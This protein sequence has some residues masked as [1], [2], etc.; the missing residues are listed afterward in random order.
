MAN[1]GY[2]LSCEEHRPNDLIR[3]AK[4]AEEAGFEF[5]LIS[6]HFHPWT[7]K[8]GQSPFAWSVLGGIAQ[9]TDKL[10]LGTGVTCPILRYHPAII[11][12]AAATIADMMP[13]RF[14]L[15]LGTGE[16]LNEH[17]LGQHWP[18]PKIRLDMLQEAVEIIR[19]LWEG[20]YKSHYGK[21]FKVENARIYTLPEQLPPIMI[22]ASGTHSAQVA[23]SIGDGFIGVGPS[24]KPIDTFNKNGGADKPKYGQLTVCWAESTEEAIKTAYEWWPNGALKGDLNQELPLPIHFEQAASMVTEQDVAKSITCSSNPEDHLAAIQQMLD[25]GYTHV[26]VH[27]VGPNQEGFIRFYQ[28]HIFPRLQ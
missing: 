12:Q 17:I 13:G 15:G 11:A 28:K 24:S 27:Q 1:V 10:I 6:D 23:A 3:Y 14:F 16:N 22:A 7:D 2:S 9:A 8:Q 25:A 20:G 18:E 19:K 5:A 4:M 21:Y 26:Y